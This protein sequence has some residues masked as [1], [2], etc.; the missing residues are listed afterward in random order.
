MLPRL[1][2]SL[3]NFGLEA[4]AEAVFLDLKIMAGL[5]IEPEPL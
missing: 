3:K 1:T 2:R 4:V 5:K